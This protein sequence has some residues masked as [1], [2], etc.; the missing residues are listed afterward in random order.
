[1]HEIHNGSDF[2]PDDDY[3]MLLPSVGQCLIFVYSWALFGSTVFFSL[4]L[5]VNELRATSFVFWQY[6]YIFDYFP[7]V[8]HWISKEAST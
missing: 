3:G 2:R 8:I 5:T 4:A 1:M 7:V 6:V